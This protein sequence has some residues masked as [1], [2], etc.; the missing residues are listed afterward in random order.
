M[1]EYPFLDNLPLFYNNLTL[2]RNNLPLLKNTL[3]LSHMCIDIFLNEIS[4]LL[5]L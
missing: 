5:F 1:L 2:L 3:F 4:Y